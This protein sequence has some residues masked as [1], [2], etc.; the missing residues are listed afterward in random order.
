MISKENIQ[1]A[2]DVVE[3]VC[4]LS[5]YYRE[6]GFK[7]RSTSAYIT[8]GNYPSLCLLIGKFTD[9]NGTY[10][11][12]ERFEVLL[13][14]EHDFGNTFEQVAEAIKREMERVENG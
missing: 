11:I 7:D 8:G 2:L 4:L 3:T 13:D 14:D 5:N 12:S 10:L 1:A 9:D 6:K